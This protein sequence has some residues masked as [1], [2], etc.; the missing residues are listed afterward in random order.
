MGAFVT[1]SIVAQDVVALYRKAISGE[2]SV[3]LGDDKG[4]W[5]NTYCGNVPFKFGDWVVVFF[6]DCNELDYTDHVI[7]PDGVLCDDWC[8]WS[9][10][11]SGIFCPLDLMADFERSA[12]EEILENCNV[13]DCQK[14]QC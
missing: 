3:R 5:N 8:T 7:S 13:I 9:E 6:N 10:D 1:A 11:G 4:T 2:V 12:L 14:K